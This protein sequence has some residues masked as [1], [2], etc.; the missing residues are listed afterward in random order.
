MPNALLEM[1]ILAPPLLFSLTIH[2]YSHARMALAFG[3]PTAK[4]M[5]RLTL[6]PLKHLDLI[7]TIAIFLVH[8]GWAKPVPVNF[9]NL[10][11]RRLGNIAVSLAGPM[12]NL[13]AAIL[14][15]LILRAEHVWQL[16]ENWGLLVGAKPILA[17]TMAVNLVLCVFNI[18][19]LF[20]LDGHHILR[21]LLP[22]EWQLHYM[23]WQVKFGR[24][25]LM[26][27]IFIPMLTGTNGPVYYLFNGAIMPLVR[28]AAGGGA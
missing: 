10:H 5:G 24:L 23:Q 18:M 20:P 25:I 3:D 28:W 21:E 8:F 4:L 2:E 13:L 26:A 27:L 14:C 17:I 22:S 1:L 15:G 7:G 19:P 11:P 9:A 16:G 12:S 6:N